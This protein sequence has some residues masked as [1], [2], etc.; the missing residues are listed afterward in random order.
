MAQDTASAQTP[1]FSRQM[2]GFIR[3][4]RNN[5]FVVGVQEFLQVTELTSHMDWTNPALVRE[6]WRTV[7]CSRL[8]DWERYN[9]LFD[10][11]WHQRGV[12]RKARVN[13]MSQR[14]SKGKTANDQGASAGQWKVD[15][16][17]LGGDENLAVKSDHQSE[18]A[19]RSESLSAMDMRH[20]YD[21]QQL[22]QAYLLA[23]RLAKKMHHRLSRRD[24]SARRGH[25]LDLRK[26]I[27]SSIAHGGTPLRLAFRKKVQKPLR[28]VM[29]MD[30]S[31]SMNQYGAFFLRFMRGVLDEFREAEAFVF[32]TKLIHISDVMRDPNLVK[33]MARL[34]L[35]TT[36]WSGGTR[37][38]D[39]L[40]NFNQH[41]AKSVLNGRTVVMILSDGYDTSPPDLLSDELARI[42]KR[43][44]RIVWLNP[45]MSWKG[46]AP[47]A[48]GMVAALPHIDLLAPA[49]SLDSLAALEPYLAKL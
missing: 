26:V 46:Y 47:I 12:R 3:A 33:A 19:S 36:G 31:G 29:L 43:A 5:G 13:G 24:R 16:V 38:G 30:A 34:S 4:L 49:H 11:Y 2:S 45:M 20:V 41:Y 18:G 7:L 10:A 48:Q 42:Q 28:L 1:S 22:E 15:H 44:K 17:E 9:D 39:C 8:A 27:R 23:E 35:L 40:R 21:P 37:I 25:K 14:T 32:H 6:T